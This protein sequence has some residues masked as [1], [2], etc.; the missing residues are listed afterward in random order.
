MARHVELLQ[1]QAADIRVELRGPSVNGPGTTPLVVAAPTGSDPVVCVHDGTQLKPWRHGEPGLRLAEDTVYQFTVECLNSAVPVEIS[2]RDQT[3]VANVNQVGGHR[4]LLVGP[5][6]FRRQVGNSEFVVRAGRHELR[7]VVE[8]TPTKI[9][10]H[11]DYLELVHDVNSLVH[12]LAFEYLRATYLPSTLTTAYDQQSTVEWLTVLAALFDDLDAAFNYVQA[13]PVRT[14]AGRTEYRRADKARGYDTQT[15][16]AIQRGL[17]RGP[18]LHAPVVGPIR[19]QLPGSCAVESLDTN[20]HRWLRQQAVDVVGRI[21][22][23]VA[24]IE[25]SRRS[26]AA[27]GRSHHRIDLEI[28]ELQSFAARLTQ[29]MSSEPFSTAT[30]PPPVGFTSLTL[31]GQPGYRDA[32]RILQLLRMSL[33]VSS[34]AV[35]TSIKEIDALYEMWCFL[36]VVAEVCSIVDTTI[37]PTTLIQIGDDGI[38]L[39]VKRGQ[40]SAV[41]VHGGTKTLTIRYNQSYDSLTGQQKPDIVIEVQHHEW[42]QIVLILDAK[43]RLDSSAGYIAAFGTPGPPS[44]AVNVLHRYRDAIAIRM[45]DAGLGRPV[46]R[47]AVLFPP[48][49]NADFETNRLWR[50]LDELGIGAIPLLPSATTHLTAW[51]AHVL[52]LPPMELASPGLPYIAY[53]HARTLQSPPPSGA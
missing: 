8:V 34:G 38:R 22:H 31:L 11:T 44:D 15:R 40:Q 3:L 50:A 12:G 16:K 24:G 47:G 46:V 43:Y 39:R 52:S 6:N 36:R 29:R 33:R 10:Y 2:H 7:F 51:L 53:E 27:A 48:D 35:A 5:V 19:A 32:Y 42:P 23:V 28:R 20:E 17:G 25:R 45:N 4:N 1:I 41:T 30:A 13:H 26:L 18:W 49:A 14:L 37:D 9:D 21:R